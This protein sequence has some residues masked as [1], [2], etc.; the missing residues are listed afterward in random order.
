MNERFTVSDV[1][2]LSMMSDAV[3]NSTQP[4]RMG[5]YFNVQLNNYRKLASVNKS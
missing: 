2:L 4:I 3:K 5:K 1:H